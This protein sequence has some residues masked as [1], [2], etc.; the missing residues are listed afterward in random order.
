MVSHM[1]LDMASLEYQN[2]EGHR[3]KEVEGRYAPLMADQMG[4]VM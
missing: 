4:V 1:G 2:W 3:G